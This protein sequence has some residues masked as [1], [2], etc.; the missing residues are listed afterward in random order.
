MGSWICPQCGG[1]KSFSHCRCLDCHLDPVPRFWAKVEKATSGCWVWTAGLCRH[2]YGMF[3]TQR[4]KRGAHRFAYE[5]LV[6]PI[7]DGLTLDHLCRNRA[8]VNPAHL[9]PITNS[10][11]ILRGMAPSAQNARKTH[12]DQGH[13]LSGTNL[14][15]RSDGARG[16]R[17]C[18]REATRRYRQRQFSGASKSA[19][20]GA[21]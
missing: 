15:R 4:K 9:E 14:F 20:E 17:Q 13:E 12:C 21:K 19:V 3:T 16:C 6:G 8:C 10:E 18:R 5:L 11:N 7:P 1:P 2:G